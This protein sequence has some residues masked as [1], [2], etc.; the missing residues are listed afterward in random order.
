MPREYAA[1]I[2]EAVEAETRRC[3]GICDAVSDDNPH[4]YERWIAGCQACR[5]AILKSAGLEPEVPD[6][7]R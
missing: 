4:R 1:L 2:K 5:G 6:A 3:A 7:K